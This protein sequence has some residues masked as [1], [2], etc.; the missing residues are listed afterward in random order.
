M[1]EVPG[2]AVL[3]DR[4]NILRQSAIPYLVT[5]VSAV[6]VGA[7]SQYTWQYVW[8]GFPTPFSQL[9]GV[10]VTFAIS[11]IGF[12]FWFLF[13]GRASRS[14][15]LLLFI[16]LLLVAW[17]AAWLLARYHSDA[18]TY[19]F[20]LFPLILAAITLKPPSASE[21]YRSIVW[22]AW[23]LASVFVLVLALEVVGVI[24]G[25]DVGDPLLE[26]EQ[27]NYWLPLAGLLGIE[28]R[29]AG[30]LGHNA[31]T[32]NA[33]AMVLIIGVAHKS[34]GRWFLIAI[35][36]F[37]LLATAS[38]TSQI[39][40]LAG[41]GIMVLTS[42]WLSQRRLLRNAAITAVV[43]ATIAV[44]L[45]LLR[46]SPNLTG[47]TGMWRYAINT[48]RERPLLGVGS[49]GRLDPGPTGSEAWNMHNLVLEAL[50][51]GGLVMALL[52][53]AVLLFAIWIVWR[54]RPSEF[55]PLAIGILATY[56]V[57]GMVQSDQWWLELSVPFLWLLLPVLLSSAPQPGHH[58]EVE[59]PPSMD[60]RQT[61]QRPQP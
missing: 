52:V 54:A 15:Y 32:G 24:P 35:A 37:V 28:G 13:Q 46:Q 3:A 5:F 42:S 45:V 57:I 48:W 34:R 17:L 8:T 14:R 58:R 39:A 19:G 16:A 53:T 23:L 49:S 38:R 31:M 11:A 41:V 60:E 29:W 20:L 55:R 9:P 36:I 4:L 43:I 51:K 30:P 61:V 1:R 47:R 10:W 12:G 44:A 22:A 2:G 7:L 27:S 56:L 59:V 18:F 6:I 50:L 25:V 33:A 26:F 40:A 21:T